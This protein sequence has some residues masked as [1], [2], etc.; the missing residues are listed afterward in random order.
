MFDISEVF[1][2]DLYKWLMV[3]EARIAANG[4]GML[5]I[6]ES[7]YETNPEVHILVPIQQPV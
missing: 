6:Y 4:I 1:I 7:S 5:N 3:K 2:D